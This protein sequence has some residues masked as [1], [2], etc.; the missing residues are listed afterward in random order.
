LIKVCDLGAVITYVAYT[1]VVLIEL[2]R[3]RHEG[4]VI[5]RQTNGVEVLVTTRET[6][7]PLEGVADLTALLTGGEGA[8]VIADCEG[9]VIA[10]VGDEVVVGVNAARAVVDVVAK[11]SAAIG[12]VAN[13]C[14][15]IGKTTYLPG[16]EVVI[17]HTNA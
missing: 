13:A 11:L 2:I 15:L 17:Y 3:V 4:A 9:D 5:V 7:T 8:H 12:C 14:T 16:V 6:H 10:T 1:V